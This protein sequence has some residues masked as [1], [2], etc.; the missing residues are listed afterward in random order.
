[1]TRYLLLLALAGCPSKGPK[2]PAY[3]PAGPK[4]CE[5]MAD[6]VVG[7][8]TPKDPVTDKPVDAHRETADKITRVLIET[9]TKDKWTE[10]AQ[11]CW[12]QLTS[13]KDVEKCSPLMTIDQRDNFGKAIEAAFPRDAEPAKPE[14]GSGSAAP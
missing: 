8:M 13:F 9:C 5:K 1:M 11:K 14:T 10:D 2:D 4:P 12:V 3:T 6:H 7:L